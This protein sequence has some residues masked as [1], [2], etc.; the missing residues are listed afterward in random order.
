MYVGTFKQ[1]VDNLR[2]PLFRIWSN[3]IV[4]DRHDVFCFLLMGFVSF[5]SSL[6]V[7]GE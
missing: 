6:L 7:V 4:D 2:L 1:C 3:E 5:L